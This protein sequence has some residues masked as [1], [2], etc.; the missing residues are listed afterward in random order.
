MRLHQ[1]AFGTDTW[2]EQHGS[3]GGEHT[4]DAEVVDEVVQGVGAFIMG[5]KMFGGGDGPWD[6]T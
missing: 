6:E 4:A 2:R 3:D 5:R 1:C